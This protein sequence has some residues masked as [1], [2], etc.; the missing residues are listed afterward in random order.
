[1]FGQGLTSLLNLPQ[2]Q[3]AHLD[4]SLREEAENYLPQAAFNIIYP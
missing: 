3:E 1:M 4:E 2:L